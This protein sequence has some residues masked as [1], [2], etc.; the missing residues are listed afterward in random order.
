MSQA[1]GSKKRIE[2]VE[3]TVYH[4][5]PTVSYRLSRRLG[6]V[7][8]PTL[9]AAVGTGGSA[10]MLDAD[11]GSLAREFFDR[12]DEKLLDD[13][14]ENFKDVTLVDGKKLRDVFAIHFRGKIDQM[15][16]WLAFSLSVEYEGLLKKVRSGIGRAALLRQTPESGSPST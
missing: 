3:Y 4:L 7:L 5:D 11:V 6:A 14:V 1:D 9:A 8:G 16:E 13:L 12:L 15:F 2:G 10:K